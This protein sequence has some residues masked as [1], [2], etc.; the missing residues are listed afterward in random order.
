MASELVS[1]SRL[2]F[3]RW[4]FKE[5][6]SLAVQTLA[7]REL[8]NTVCQENGTDAARSVHKRAMQ[9]VSQWLPSVPLNLNSYAG[10]W[11]ASLK[12]RIVP[13]KLQLRTMCSIPWFL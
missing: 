6:L 5:L 4:R 8:V 2:L 9:T 13:N 12:M 1:A 10:V 7:G 11:P 3:E